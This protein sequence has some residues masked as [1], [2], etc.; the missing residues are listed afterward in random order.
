MVLK[1]FFVVGFM[2]III[3]LAAL[4]LFVLDQDKRDFEDS[5][6]WEDE[7]KNKFE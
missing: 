7:S 1:F 6:I 2:V 3:C 4:I 5:E